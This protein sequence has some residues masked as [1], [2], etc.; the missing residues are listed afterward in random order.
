MKLKSLSAIMLVGTFCWTSQATAESA[1]ISGRVVDVLEKPQFRSTLWTELPLDGGPAATNTSLVAGDLNADGMT[2]AV[3]VKRST[4]T[5]LI[6]RSNGTNRFDLF[7]LP[8]STPKG[9]PIGLTDTQGDGC[10]DL[11][12]WD[13][14]KGWLHIGTSDCKA[15]FNW[16][17][18]VDVSSKGPL[19]SAAAEP[20]ALN[21]QPRLLIST[22]YPN[23]VY[24]LEN[25]KLRNDERL[26]PSLDVL[27]L[28]IEIELPG[29][30]ILA[31]VNGD[32]RLDFLSIL[33]VHPG[34]IWVAS[35][36]AETSVPYVSLFET[37]PDPMLK[38]IELNG[39]GRDDFLVV[40]ENGRSIG[41]FAVFSTEHGGIVRSIS[42]AVPDFIE[43]RSIVS[44]DFDGDGYV[45]LAGVRRTEAAGSHVEIWVSLR[46]PPKGIPAV[47]IR[48]NRSDEEL[49]SDQ[50]GRFE[51]PLPASG[52][53]RLEFSK[54]GYTFRPPSFVIEADHPPK[55][56]L[57][58]AE[59]LSSP[60]AATGRALGIL[61]DPPGPHA[62]L[63]FRPI[64]SAE[65]LRLG[66]LNNAS[67][68]MNWG[69]TYSHCPDGYAVLNLGNVRRD[70]SGRVKRDLSGIC[71]RLPAQDILTSEHRYAD[72]RCPENFVLTGFRAFESEKRENGHA[73]AL[74]C[75]AIDRSRYQLGPEQPG[76]Y[77]G[78][79]YS[80]R[81]EKGRIPRT[82]LPVAL[83]FGAGRTIWQSRTD[84]GCAG[85][86]AG[87]LFVS[88]DGETC[89]EHRFR[90]L[91]YSGAPGD[92]EQGTAV[93]M[94][95]ECSSLEDPNDPLSGCSK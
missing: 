12:L 66:S 50:S 74:R 2:D 14:T 15:S 60:D 56:I 18:P 35:G 88:I 59:D 84:G 72:N 65:N 81:F 52:E 28:G 87:G 51:L 90:R 58:A 42:A 89:M 6:L 71:C 85:G 67:S 16:T 91:E 82:R 37:F 68:M 73:G 8:P 78:F 38:P 86:T 26:M 43:P 1:A 25:G 46:L 93:K 94:F 54:A 24:F 13:R 29:R 31:D 34:I 21:R 48:S 75:T 92:P 10:A 19:Y 47:S 53:V 40:P 79:A 17:T 27:R 33:G 95:P 44:G 9:I 22:R 11:V 3:Y 7:P 49:V 62:C 57:A 61:G 45:D 70:F 63:G 39:D 83:R 4:G 20:S 30:A 55:R 41:W 77:W 23:G 5:L 64:D 32:G 36:I 69:T 76:S 80:M